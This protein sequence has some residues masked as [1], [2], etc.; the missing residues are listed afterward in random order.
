[1]GIRVKVESENGHDESAKILP[2]MDVPQ[3]MS[4]SE[5]PKESK[6]PS[7]KPYMPPLPL[8]QQFAKA[9]LDAQI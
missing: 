8:P 7:L 1:M 9:K 6:P 4:E 2:N 5:K 3:Q